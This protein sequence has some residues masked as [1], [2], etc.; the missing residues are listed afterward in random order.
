MSWIYTFTNF[1]LL[2]TVLIAIGSAQA[3][4]TQPGSSGFVESGAYGS[5]GIT[6]LFSA[7]ATFKHYK[8]KTFFDA[9]SGDCGVSLFVMALLIGVASTTILTYAGYSEP[10]IVGLF[11]G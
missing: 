1:A 3:L 8:P 6:V 7:L 9:F 5:V 4:A 11:T 2:A 10:D